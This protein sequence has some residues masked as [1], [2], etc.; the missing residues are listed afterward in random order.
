MA[1]FN[2]QSSGPGLTYADTCVNAPTVFQIG[3]NCPKL[4]EAYTLDFGD[5]SRPYSTTATTPVTHPYTKPGQYFV[6]LRIITKTSAGGICKDTLI[7]DTLT[8]LETPPDIHL[9]ADTAICNKKGITL[10]IKVQAK[11]YVWLVNGAVAGRQRTIKLDRPGYYIVV[12]LA[13]NGEC[14]KSD[15][16]EV[17]IK[18]PP[19][20]DLGPDTVFCYRSSV[21]LTVPQQTWTQFQW[22]NGEIR[23]Q[24]PFPKEEPIPLRL[25]RRLTAPPAKTR[26][27]FGLVSCLNYDWL[28]I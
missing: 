25:S 20:L 4:K 10:D 14:F 5:G 8:I 24:F 12:G 28:P 19:S 3:P 11:L 2:D 9:G 16:I 26:I 21:N 1:N 22:S 6:S 15:T 23:E 7:K 27:R 13:A 17:Q 18:P